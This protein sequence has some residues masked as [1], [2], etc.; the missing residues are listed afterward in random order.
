MIRPN[1]VDKSGNH[2]LDSNYMAS[3]IMIEWTGVEV[4]D[5]ATGVCPTLLLMVAQRSEY[6]I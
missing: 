6:N 1:V 3:N 2:Q 4:R 5:E